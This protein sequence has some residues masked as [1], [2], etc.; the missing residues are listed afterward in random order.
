H[1][2]EHGLEANARH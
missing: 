2:S 1:Q